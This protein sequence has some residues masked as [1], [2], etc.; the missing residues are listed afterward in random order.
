MF[1]QEPLGQRDCW[2]TIQMR[3][4]SFAYED[5]D[6]KQRQLDNVSIELRRG[7]AIALV[8]SSGGGKST[9]LNLLRGLDHPSHVDVYRDGLRMENGLRT[10]SQATSLMPQDPQIFSDH[11]LQHSFRDGSIRR[12]N[13]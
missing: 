9:L 12:G 6:G 4:L 8:G 1:S 7:Q 11:S 5:V 10:L 2:R 3:D 13:Q